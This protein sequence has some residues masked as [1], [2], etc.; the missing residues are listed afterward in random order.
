M[1]GTQSQITDFREKAQRQRLNSLKYDVR[2]VEG[3]VV[4][5]VALTPQIAIDL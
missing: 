2:Y 5:D 1:G 4:D 3:D